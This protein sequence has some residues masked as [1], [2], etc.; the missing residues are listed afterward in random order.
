MLPKLQLPSAAPAAVFSHYL[1]P[2]LLQVAVYVPFHYGVCL[3]LLSDCC[4]FCLVWFD[5]AVISAFLIALVYTVCRIALENPIFDFCP[6]QKKCSSALYLPCRV[7]RLAPSLVVC[8]GSMIASNLMFS[9]PPMP[10]HPYQYIAL[11]WLKVIQITSVFQVW[12]AGYWVCCEWECV[13]SYLQV[14][15][16]RSLNCPIYTLVYADTQ[17]TRFIPPLPGAVCA[18]YVLQWEN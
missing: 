14:V 3:L 17:R 10:F 4:C 18:I 7:S 1:L 12:G 5:A 11:P 8:K 15:A 2:L 6:C 13:Q 16:Y 9:N